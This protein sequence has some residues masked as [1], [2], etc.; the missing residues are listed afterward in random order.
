[1]S[2]FINFVDGS[3]LFSPYL[4]THEVGQE[5]WPLK[6]GAEIRRPHWSPGLRGASGEPDARRTT[7]HLNS[8]RTVM[9]KPSRKLVA[10]AGLPIVGAL[11]VG[12]I[13]LANSSTITSK[14]LGAG[15]S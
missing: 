13:A 4:R 12:G 15:T 8:R 11:A 14:D 6:G 2:G 10:L 1:M 3:D 9:H 5:G 7:T